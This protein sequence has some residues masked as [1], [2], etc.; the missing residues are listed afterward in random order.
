MFEIEECE[1]ADETQGYE[2]A[3]VLGR[4]LYVYRAAAGIVDQRGA[5]AIFPDEET[6]AWAVRG[7]G[8]LIG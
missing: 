8:I 1:N 3:H 4:K 5:V 7:R 2:I 6:G